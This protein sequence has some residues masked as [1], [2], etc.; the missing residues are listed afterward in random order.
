MSH[1]RILPLCLL[2]AG[3]GAVLDPQG[4]VGSAQRTILFNAV[5]I[6]LVIVVP[7]IV[8][9][10]ALAWWFRAG[11]PRARRRPEWS[12]S[13][14]LELI[15]WSIPLMVILFL[16]GITWI[17][18]HALDP[19]R[20]LA[21]PNKPLDVQV[22]ALDWKWLFIYPEQD[23]AA[24]NRLVIPVGTPVQFH[25][26]SASVMTAFFIPQLG[27]MIYAM[28]GME[29]RL[30]LQADTAG[31]FRGMASHYSGAGFPGMN[32]STEAVAPE[33]FAAWIDDTRREARTLDRAAYTE[34]GR[35][36]R[37]V[38]PFAFGRVDPALFA[39]IVSG[40]VPP[41]VPGPEETRR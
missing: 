2:F 28:N 33:R 10:L 36:S 29:S 18:A 25:I 12:Y 39:G 3:C 40:A 7:V 27:S 9:T 6:M 34:L 23:V 4:P 17:G 1:R 22:V 16:G 24:V 19:A 32:F 8:G 14:S 15:T 30:N 37:D 11:N 35:P 13:G 31:A 21:S 20:A 41:A 26:T 5:A 38:A